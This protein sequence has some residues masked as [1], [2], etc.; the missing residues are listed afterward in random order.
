MN[1][2]NEA[3]PLWVRR[4]KNPAK[5]RGLKIEVPKKDSLRMF[6]IFCQETRNVRKRQGP[7]NSTLVGIKRD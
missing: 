3:G 1:H 7:P 6:L 5:P 2:L 4:R